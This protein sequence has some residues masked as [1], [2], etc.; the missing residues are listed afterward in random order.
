[1][2]RWLRA[3]TEGGQGLCARPDLTPRLNL[4]FFFF[5]PGFAKRGGTFSCLE[6]VSIES[7]IP[8]D[9]MEI[10]ETISPN[11]FLLSFNV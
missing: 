10:E 3:V 5:S 11:M 4:C 1:M 8:I 9:A 7:D 2:D 6:M